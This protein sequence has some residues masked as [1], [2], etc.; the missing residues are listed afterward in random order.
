[1]QI[2]TR[3]A[4]VDRFGAEGDLDALL[5]ELVRRD[6]MFQDGDRFLSLAVASKPELAAERIRGQWQD[7]QKAERLPRQVDRDRPRSAPVERS[8]TGS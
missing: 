2:R 7:E 3:R 8:C 4:I 5:E 1:M 6:L